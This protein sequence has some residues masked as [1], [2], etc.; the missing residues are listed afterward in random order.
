[1]GERDDSRTT[2]AEDSATESAV[3]QQ[4][5]NLH[6]TQVT[7]EELARE[8]GGESAGFAE[9]DAVERAVRDLGAAGLLHHRGDFVLASRAAL[10]FSQLLDR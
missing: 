7:L 4:V 6:P 8:I 1:M 3:L 5:L 9:R 2:E 10:R